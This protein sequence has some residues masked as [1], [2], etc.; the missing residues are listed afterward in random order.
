MLELAA[1]PNHA[2][3]LLQEFD[4]LSVSDEDWVA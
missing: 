2:D 4:S 3:R 1:C